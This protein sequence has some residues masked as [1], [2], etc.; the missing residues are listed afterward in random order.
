MRAEFSFCDTGEQARALEEPEVCP[1]SDALLRRLTTAAS[2]IVR[3]KSDVGP[4]SDAHFRLSRSCR[5]FAHAEN[6]GVGFTLGRM[7][8]SQQFRRV[9]TS[10][11]NQEKI[12]ARLAMSPESEPNQTLEPTAPSGRGSS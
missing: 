7:R 3:L 11:P 10:F 8:F 12:A 9:V 4:V 2:S 5:E 6:A 1:A